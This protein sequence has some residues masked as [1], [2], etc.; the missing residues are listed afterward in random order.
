MACWPASQAPPKVT[1]FR[2]GSPCR[3]RAFEEVS[4]RVFLTSTDAGAL[5]RA[6]L[7]FRLW[8]EDNDLCDEAC[9]MRGAEEAE[10]EG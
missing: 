2:Y 9:L 6:R 10:W 5:A 1:G 3:P 8:S 4:L 7:A